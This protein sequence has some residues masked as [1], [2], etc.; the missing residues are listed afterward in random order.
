MKSE[1]FAKMW[2]KK[3]MDQKMKGTIDDCIKNLNF[4]TEGDTTYMT[5]LEGSPFLWVL[6][7]EPKN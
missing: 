3:T 1:H 4:F 7:R 5:Q 2:N 6:S